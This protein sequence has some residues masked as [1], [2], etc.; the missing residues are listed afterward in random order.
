MENIAEKFKQIIV[1]QMGCDESEATPSA[2]FL[3]DLGF[4]SLDGVEVVMAC[5]EA[6]GIE[7]PDEDVDGIATVKQAM[8]YLER[9]LAA[10]K[11]S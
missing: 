7:I 5:E 8:E 6:F 4:D 11:Q 2:N 9:R 1:R 10:K 3:E